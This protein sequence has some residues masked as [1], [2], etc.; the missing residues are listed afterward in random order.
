MFFRNHR[1]KG[2]YLSRLFML[3]FTL[4]LVVA[5]A[6]RSELLQGG[7]EVNDS[8]PPASFKALEASVDNTALVMPKQDCIC[9]NNAGAEL[10]SIGGNWKI[11]DKDNWILD[12]GSDAN[13]GQQSLDIIQHYKL[14][15]ICF[16]GRPFRDGKIKM[17]YFLADGRAPEGTFP[18]EDAIQFD[19]A[20]V[21]A[22]EI[23]G[24]WKLVQ[25]SMWMLDFNSNQEEARNAEE[26]VKYYG[27]TRQC[28]VGRPGP[29][30]MYWR[31]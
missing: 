1:A 15:N 6:C 30:M 12:F 18:G 8:L 27:F 20:R 17:M 5:S 2:V 13:M 19:P 11:V 10:K 22:E 4:N 25:D 23:D 24:R 29:P 28:F 26:I 7:V 16:V 3:T 31:K 21:K 14:N 9:F